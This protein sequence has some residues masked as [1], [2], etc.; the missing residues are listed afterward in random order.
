MTRDTK[1]TKKRAHVLFDGDRHTDGI[2]DIPEDNTAETAHEGSGST[3]DGRC[4]SRNREDTTQ[5]QCNQKRDSQL[6][7]RHSPILVSDTPP[8]SGA[9]ASLASGIG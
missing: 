1:G 4:E 9:M 3:D 2:T 8:E 6:A 7:K 5:G